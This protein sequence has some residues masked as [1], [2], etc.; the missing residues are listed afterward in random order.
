MLIVPLAALWLPG[1]LWLLLLDLHRGKTLL[2]I[3]ALSLGISL[4]ILSLSLTCLSFLGIR[5]GALIIVLSLAGLV[6][7]LGLRVRGLGINIRLI[8]MSRAGF[9]PLLLL[10]LHMFLWFAYFW[11]YPVFPS[12]QSPDPLRHAAFVQEVVDG[13]GVDAMREARYGL[14]LHFIVGFIIQNS[15][16]QLLIILR[17]FVAFLESMTV[18]LVY[19]VAALLS[20]RRD[21]A[22]TSLI[23]AVAVPIGVVHLIGA[24]TYANILA[25]FL[26]L[27]AIY[28]MQQSLQSRRLKDL[29]TVALVG[30]GLLL[31]HPF[32]SI[33]FLTFA[34]LF[35]TVVMLHYRS[36]LRGY[37]YS[38]FSL[39]LAAAL[40]VSAFPGFLERALSLLA[41]YLSSPTPIAV[42]C[43]VWLQN[44]GFFLG[45]PGMLL[46]VFALLA[47]SW[48]VNWDPNIHSTP[49]KE[50]LIFF[51]FGWFLYASAL[52]IQGGEI[53]RLVLH[54]LLPGVFILATGLSGPVWVLCGRVS[55]SVSS[56]SFTRAL[57]SSLLLLVFL[58]ILV[59][60]CATYVLNELQG[61]G[62][63]ERQ[64]AVYESM[65]WAQQNTRSNDL[66]ASVNLAE[67]R[68]LPIVANRRLERNYE[69]PSDRMRDVLRLTKALYIVIPTE[70]LR[71]DLS[72]WACTVAF[73]NDY[74]TILK[75]NAL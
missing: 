16:D 52:T 44:M 51:M 49:E 64:M 1:L 12:S 3:I 32:V 24:G 65:R 43:Q 9:V 11:K 29:A 4:S 7:A 15:S 66:F 41:R 13:R 40:G 71:I 67:Y 61:P 37:C 45:L 47:Y 46:L 42:I 6:A 63:R 23:Y 25:D 30:G 10:L 38:V 75:L 21:A 33:I 62:Q 20:T 74:V 59:G 18:L 19:F 27:T 73:S 35:S 53:W 14:G 68:Y 48:K 55:K 50:V 31:S 58:A 60:S 57:R 22:L 70:E 8:N 17:Y 26:C 5:P 2:E 34:W 69:V 54:S 39:T 56:R 28:F 72:M 36:I